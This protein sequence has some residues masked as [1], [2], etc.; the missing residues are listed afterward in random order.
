MRNIDLIPS[1]MQSHESWLIQFIMGF[2]GMK[3]AMYKKIVHNSY[4]KYPSKIPV[5][6]F[7]YCDVKTEEIFG[8]KVW[9]I[10]KKNTISGNIVLF[11]H[12]GAYYANISYLHWSFVARLAEITDSTIVVPDYPLAPEF[13]CFD[14]YRFMNN[15]YSK[16]LSSY[17]EKQIVLMGDSAGGGLA[18]GFAQKISFE[19][20]RQPGHI[21]LFSPW[22]D[23]T[24]TNPEISVLDKSDKILSIDGLKMAGINYAGNIGITDYRVSPIYGDLSRLGKL[25]IFVGTNEI[26]MADARMLKQKLDLMG[27]DFNYFVYPDMFHDWVLVHWLKESRKVLQW[28]KVYFEALNKR[29]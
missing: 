25:T 10:S 14:T 27:I 17:P 15:L 1:D 20:I 13:T 6:L 29:N 16:I 5:S 22:L 9:T 8:R 2:M 12:G 24:M 4:N 3:K 28:I 18:L 23:A 19:N 26:L 21:F 11:L 7:K